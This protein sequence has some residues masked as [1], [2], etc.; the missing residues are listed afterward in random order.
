MLLLVFPFIFLFSF[1][2]AL[3]LVILQDCEVM[4]Q[5]SAEGESMA[6]AA[7]TASS[8]SWVCL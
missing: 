1:P 4:I 3:F 5:Q 7:M 2:Y 8:T 6:V